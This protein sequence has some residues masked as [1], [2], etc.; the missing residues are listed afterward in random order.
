[1]EFHQEAELEFIEHT[2]HNCGQYKLHMYVHKD[3]SH[4]DQL[5]LLMVTSGG[6]IT[7]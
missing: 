1:M 5:T 6:G 2:P 7:C 4:D 3:I